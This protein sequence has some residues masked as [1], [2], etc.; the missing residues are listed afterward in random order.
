MNKILW[1]ACA[2]LL[3]SLIGTAHAQSLV[4]DKAV[5]RATVGKMPNGAAFLQIENKGSDDV[6]LSGSSPAASR[7]EI[8]TMTVEGDVMKMRALDQLELKAGQRLDMKPGSGIHIMLMGLKKPLTAGE[9]FSLT[10][11]FRKAGKIETTVDVVDMKMPM[12]KGETHEHHD[13]HQHHKE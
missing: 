7:V 3:L 13:H 10:L 6:L 9:K 11:N 8:H 12:K 2:L 5:A 4:I 1:R